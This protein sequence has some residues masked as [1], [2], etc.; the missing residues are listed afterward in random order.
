[1]LWKKDRAE[2]EALRRQAEN[3]IR[4]REAA[5]LD[6]K[7]S[8]LQLTRFLQQINIEDGLTAIGDNLAGGPERK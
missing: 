2:L 6:L 4:E 5:R 8:A 7:K 1:M 3:D